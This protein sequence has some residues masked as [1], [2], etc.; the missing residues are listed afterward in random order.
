[1]FPLAPGKA[2]YGQMALAKL[3]LGIHL[4]RGASLSQASSSPERK[5]GRSQ[6]N[7]QFKKQGLG[8][9]EVHKFS[10]RNVNSSI[11]IRIHVILEL[12]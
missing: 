5:N 12:H 10:I 6:N 11:W 9:Q 8:M 7:Y 1:M 3:Y 4:E 2:F